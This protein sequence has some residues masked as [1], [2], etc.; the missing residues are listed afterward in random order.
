MNNE[1]EN[2][3][4][5][6]ELDKLTEKLNNDLVQSTTTQSISS[7][8]VTNYNQSSQTS[9]VQLKDEN[10]NDFIIEKSSELITSSLEAINTVKD[11]ITRTIDPD[12]LESLAALIKAATSSID[13]LNSINLER[14]KY[15]S[16]KRLKQLEFES[17]KQLG[18][19]SGN[20]TNAIF[21]G[22]REDM[23][24]MLEN[25]KKDSDTSEKF[26]EDVESQ[27]V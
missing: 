2:D 13:T 27:R 22:S 11:R 20:T 18:K 8:N 10:L 16:A 24:K 6:T 14:R 1:Q 9:A 17:K 21:V 3:T 5:L 19:R 15:K 12:E 25:I 23:L 4:L 7:N 26:V